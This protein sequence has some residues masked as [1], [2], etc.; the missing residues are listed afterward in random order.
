MDEVITF[1]DCTKRF[2]FTVKKSIIPK[3]SKPED[4]IKYLSNKTT[5]E[6]NKDLNLLYYL[7][8]TKGAALVDLD[9]GVKEYYIDGKL[10]DNVKNDLDLKVIQNYESYGN[11]FKGLLE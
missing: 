6:L 1:K 8:N 4:Y 5:W 11:K 3:S 10:L 7:H 9:T 2:Q